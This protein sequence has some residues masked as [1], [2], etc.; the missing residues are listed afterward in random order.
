MNYNSNSQKSTYHSILHLHSVY[1][2]TH[3]HTHMGVW[4]VRL[5]KHNSI[6]LLSTLTFI[7]ILTISSITTIVSVLAIHRGVIRCSG[8]TLFKF[9]FDTFFI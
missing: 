7:F 2:Y 5:V 9:L 6:V 4:A 8:Q 3:T 1:V